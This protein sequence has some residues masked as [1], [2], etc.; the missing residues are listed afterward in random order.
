MSYFTGKIRISIIILICLVVETILITTIYYHLKNNSHHDTET[1]MINTNLNIL[2]YINLRINQTKY[3]IERNAA[4]FRIH[5]VYLSGNNYTDFLQI[6]KQPSNQ[7]VESYVF[8]PKISDSDLL[9]YQQFCKME[10]FSDCMIKQFNYTNN[11]YVQAY[12]RN[13]YYPLLFMEPQLPP[14]DQTRLQ[15]FDFGSNNTTLKIINIV[16]NNAGLTASFRINLLRPDVM[17]P[18]SHGVLLIYPTYANNYNTDI[19]GYSFALI[20]LGNIF[21]E[22][23]KNLDITIRMKDVDIFIFDVTQDN[24]VNISSNNIS[25]IYKAN[26]KMYENIWFHTD[27]SDSDNYLFKYNFNLATRQWLICFKYS[28]Y[29][30]HRNADNLLIVIPCVMAGISIL[31]DVII[32]I[33]YQ[34]IR[35]IKHRSSLEKEKADISM[36]MLG[37]VNHE[38]RNPLNIINGLVKFQIEN[39]RQYVSDDGNV[40]IDRLMFDSI[41]SDLST[42]SGSCDMLEH[43]VTDVL[44]VNKLD[45]GKLELNNRNI[46][47]EEFMTDITKTISQKIN[48]KQTVILKKHYDPNL[49]LCFDAYRMKQILLNFL[50][51]AVK[52][53]VTGSITIKIEQKEN[54]YRFSVTDTGCGIRDDNKGEIFQRF[55]QTN[56]D[57]ASRYGGIG[58][59]LY[60][61]KGLV[62]RMGGVIGFDSISTD[63]SIELMHNG[64]SIDKSIE[65]MHSSTSIDKSIELMHSSTSID[66]SIELMHSST[67]IDKSIEL[68][69]SVTYGTGST[70]WAEFP[71]ILLKSTKMEHEIV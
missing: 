12:G 21:D 30:I 61:C 60:L 6:D 50:T 58:L 67:S 3:L 59:G 19:I 47:M 43:I 35:S 16:N 25:L 17:N 42:V 41:I 11:T 39:M 18:Y 14:A 28:D 34:F 32:V 4:F 2:S 68:T 54:V 9:D 26:M 37:Y 62:E 44:D 40:E 51:N 24:Y 1:L 57:D 27:L 29:F 66:K 63:K 8:V 69:H 13:Y 56:P 48:E 33:L 49:V 65:L 46:N 22:A 5:G 52:Y 31:L 55:K 23:I 38:I 53:T 36:N 70:F 71:I 20:R 10:I 7:Y 45:L 64:T 15:G